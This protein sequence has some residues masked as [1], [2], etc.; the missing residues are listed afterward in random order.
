MSI[1]PLFPDLMTRGFVLGWEFID[2]LQNHTDP[3]EWLDIQ[4]A[5]P[6]RQKE[7]IAGRNLVRQLAR[8]LG[9]P[10][11]P[12]RRTDDRS[13]N[14]PTDRLGSLSHCTTLC[15]AAVSTMDTHQS[16]GVDVEQNGRIEAKLWETLFTA[17]ERAYLDQLDPAV[18][19]VEATIFFSSKEAYYKCQFP[20]TKSWV[21]FQDVELQRTSDTTLAVT[22]ANSTL[23]PWH[24]SPIHTVLLGD[25]HVA[26]LMVLPA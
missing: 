5:A 1:K 21:G 23:R 12:L 22:A 15:A 13:P 6:A 26:T 10:D 11:A 14:W 2:N 4:H 8:S 7:F 20:L 25:A 19:S 17:R 18:A 3:E 24:G 16:V 9:L